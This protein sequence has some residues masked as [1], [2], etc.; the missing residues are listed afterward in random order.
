MGKGGQLWAGCGTDIH[1]AW[2][3][4]MARVYRKGKQEINVGQKRDLSKL[5]AS[6]KS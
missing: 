3:G 5:E 4:V 1:N 6:V 2:Q